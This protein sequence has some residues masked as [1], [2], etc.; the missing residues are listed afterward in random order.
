M[1]FRPHWVRQGFD[2]GLHMVAVMALG[3]KEI[4]LHYAVVMG[5]MR[6]KNDELIDRISEGISYRDAPILKS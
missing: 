4:Q 5:L 3:Q 2:K 6:K 1:D